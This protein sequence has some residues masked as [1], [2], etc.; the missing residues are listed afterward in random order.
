MALSNEILFSKKRTW[1]HDLPIS[2]LMQQ[3]VENPGV[4]SL[5]AGLVD[6]NS[7]PVS[8]TKNAF[9]SLFSDSGAAREALQ[10]GTTAGSLSLRRLL[11]THLTNLEQKS[12]E[13]LGVTVDRF[14]AILVTV[15]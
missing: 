13:E 7:L 2:Y 9:E 8:I 5:A 4:L 14:T 1:S 11:L 3:G 15:G 6:Q 12:A 10:Y